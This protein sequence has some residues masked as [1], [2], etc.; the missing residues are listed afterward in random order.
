[1]G[2]VDDAGQR[3]IE[4]PDGQAARRIVEQGYDQVAERHRA[5]SAGIRQDERQRYTDELLDRLP[6]GARVLELG[7]GQGTPTTRL[8]AERFSV[9]GVDISARQLELARQ[10][11]P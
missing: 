7:C 5:W 8:L 1:M 4:Q 11:V 10:A 2:T 3:P 9:T 6:A